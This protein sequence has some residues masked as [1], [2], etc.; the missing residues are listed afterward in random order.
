MESIHRFLQDPKMSFFLFGPRG[1]GKSTWVRYQFPTALRIDLLDPETDRVYSARPERLREAIFGQSEQ[2]ILIDE[3]QKVPALLDVV[4]QLIEEKRGLKFILTG[5][6]ARKLKKTGVDL[7]AGRAL[8]KTLHPFA[9]AELGA[10]FQLTQALQT[11][12][13]PIVMAAPEPA[14]VLKSY[15]ALYVREDVQMEGL[16]RN[17]GNFSRFLEAI[18]FSHGE[19]LNINN[20]ARECEVERKVVTNYITILEDLLL[21]FRVPVFAKRSQRAVISHSKFY[22]FDTGV[23]QSL[24]PHGPLDRPGMIEGAALEGLVAQQLRAWLAYFADDHQLYFWRTQA[25]TEVD[26]VIY[27][28]DIFWAIEVK[29]TPRVRPEDLRGLT[30]FRQEYPECQAILLYRGQERLLQKEIL[31]LP[32]EVF[33]QQ[34]CGRVKKIV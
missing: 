23:Y 9:A 2:V 15:V 26:F 19:V 12:L 7:L 8:L 31:C 14:E 28:N 32:V 34:L 13:L 17:V 20:V 5:S 30:S 10:Q 1:S 21:A 4:H 33:L 6:S 24:R 27:G 22:L 16:V 18:S 3:V 29:S 25:Q 11:G